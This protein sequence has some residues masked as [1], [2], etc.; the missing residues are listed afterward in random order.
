VAVTF[1]AQ[2]QGRPSLRVG[3]GRPEILGLCEHDVARQI[4]GANR[5]LRRC[6]AV[7]FLFAHSFFAV[8][9]LTF[10]GAHVMSRTLLWTLGSV[11]IAGWLAVLVLD[12]GRGR[13]YHRARNENDTSRDV[14]MRSFILFFWWPFLI[15]PVWQQ[16][17]YYSDVRSGRRDRWLLFEEGEDSARTWSLSDGTGFHGSV[18]DGFLSDPSHV[19][20]DY[21]DDAMTGAANWL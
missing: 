1:P 9:Q 6:F 17:R 8:A 16:F 10:G 7:G 21:E 2:W 19:F 4:A 15:T 18:A 13:L 14:L 3:Q 11:W 20:A 5:I 12:C